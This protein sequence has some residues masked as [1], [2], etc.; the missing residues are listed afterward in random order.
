METDQVVTEVIEVVQVVNAV[1]AE[2]QWRL[3]RS[4]DFCFPLFKVW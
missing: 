2:R 3:L 1:N 4:F